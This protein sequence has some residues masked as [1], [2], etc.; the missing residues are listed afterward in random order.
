MIRVYKY[1]IAITLILFAA[2]SAHA[3]W[4]QTF[5]DEFDG[6]SLS[7]NWLYVDYWGTQSRLLTGEKSCYLSSQVSLSGGSVYLTA[8]PGTVADCPPQDVSNIQYLSGQIST[9]TSFRQAYGYFEVRAKMPKGKGLWPEFRLHRVGGTLPPKGPEIVVAQTYGSAN[10][11]LQQYDAVDDLDNVTQ[12]VNSLVTTADLSADFHFYGVDWQPGMLIWYFDGVEVYRYAGTDV[13]ADPMYMLLNLTVGA[14]VTGDPDASTVFPASM[15]VDYVHVYARV[16]DG[17]PDTL[18]PTAA[19]TEPPPK[20]DKIA[21]KIAIILPFNGMT[22][23]RN[24]SI[25]LAAAA[26][27][28]VKVTSISFSVNGTTMCSVTNKSIDICTWKVPAA[29][30]VSVYT[31]IATAKD[32]AGNVGTATIKV[33]AK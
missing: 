27:D 9:T 12:H 7:N 22:V 3:G 15:V 18:P 21:P 28:N 5:A 31:I 30:N 11:A 24:S 8:V 1:L 4:Q 2:S 20:V 29:T 32:S 14:N 13:Y 23:K 19:P 25:I 16:N 33:N 17:Q 6:T 26:I 10:Q